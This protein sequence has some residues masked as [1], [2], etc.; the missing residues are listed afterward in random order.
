MNCL[1][2]NIRGVRGVGK[3]NWVRS[4]KNKE[5]VSFIALQEI[6]ASG[7]FEETFRGFW[8]I[9]SMEFEV[10]E[11]C[12]RSGGLVSMWDPIVF[13]KIDCIKHNNFLILKGKIKEIEDVVFEVNVYAPQNS[14][15]KRNLW[16]SFSTIIGG[17]SGVWLIMGDF[18][19]VRTSEERKGSQF[20]AR[21]AREFNQFIACNDLHDYNMRGGKFT[22][23]MENDR[24]RK[25]SKIDR[26]LVSR[27]LMDRWPT[28]CLRVLPR[29]YSDHNPLFLKMV[30]NNY[31]PKPFRLFNS[32]MEKPGFEEVVD[33]A[34][35]SFVGFGA[36]DVILT[37][38]F[39]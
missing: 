15:D 33:S 5:G 6:Q 37:M 17:E 20:K 30:E 23:L 4:I 10:V 25:M 27:E 31:A 32:W 7:V 29:L 12:G 3:G 9:K 14:N 39:R 2:L 13:K 8:G 38:K 21:C 11:P 24:G 19:T 22:F 18:N 28:T 34:L 26:V 36:P 1:S 16:N 35:E